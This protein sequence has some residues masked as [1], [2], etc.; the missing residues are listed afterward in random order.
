M[1]TER[2]EPTDLGHQ[3]LG[4]EGLNIDLDDVRHRKQRPQ[5]AERD[6]VVERDGEALAAKPMQRFDK[7]LVDLRCLD[8]LND[9][10]LRRQQRRDALQDQTAGEVDQGSLSTKYCFEIDIGEHAEND[11]RRCLVLVIDDR[12]VGHW[13]SSEEDFV[14]D[15]IEAAIE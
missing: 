6:P 15:Y 9:H 5:L 10:S 7:A 2:L 12:P 11:V 1:N 13:S 14:A 8:D 3:T 4:I